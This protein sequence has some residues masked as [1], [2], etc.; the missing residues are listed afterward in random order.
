ML[1]AGRAVRSQN[2]AF[3]PADAF[4]CV[5]RFFWKWVGASRGGRRR[6]RKEGG[7]EGRPLL[8]SVLTCNCHR[9]GLQLSRG[10]RRRKISLGLD[11]NRFPSDP[12]TQTKGTRASIKLTH[13]R[14]QLRS[15]PQK[16]PRGAPLDSVIH[17][18]FL[19]GDS[20]TAVSVLTR[21]P[22]FCRLF[23][24]GFFF[25]FFFLLL[26]FSLWSSTYP[27]ISAPR[28]CSLLSC[29]FLPLPI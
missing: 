4:C 14:F 18:D 28:T 26:F 24:P 10:A 7:G 3:L 19:L 27:S 25:F 9:W 21:G 12:R 15:L 1:L 8:N 5:K 6:A 16:S 22:A 2:F 11:D 29:V 20:I 23:S 13:G 17:D